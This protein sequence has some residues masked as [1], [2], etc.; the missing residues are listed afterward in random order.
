[1]VAYFWQNPGASAKHGFFSAVADALFGRETI[2]VRD[3]RVLY[4]PY[5]SV[6]RAEAYGRSL[7]SAYPREGPFVIVERTERGWAQLGA[8]L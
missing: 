6:A 8:P 7:K 5:R 1:V 4:G 3:K 2:Y